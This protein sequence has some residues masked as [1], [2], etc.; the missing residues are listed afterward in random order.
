MSD[1]AKAAIAE[2]RA[3]AKEL[4]RQTANLRVAISWHLFGRCRLFCLR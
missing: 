2:T 1:E 3:K 4:L